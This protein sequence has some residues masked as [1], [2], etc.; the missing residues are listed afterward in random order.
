MNVNILVGN[1]VRKTSVL[2]RRPPRLFWLCVVI[3]TLL[4]VIYYGLV[5]ADV[6]VSEARF[7]V[8][9]PQ[10]QGSSTLGQLLGTNLGPAQDDT[11]TV[12]DYMLS[13]DALLELDRQLQVR[14]SFGRGD[15][16]A[17]FP[18][19]EYDD[20][21]ENM[22]RYYQKKIEVY[23]DPASSIATLKVRSFNAQE[24][25]A[26]NRKLLDM[27]ESLVN[28]INERAR[29]D[30]L[31]HAASDLKE[32]ERKAAEAALALAEYRNHKGIIDPDKQSSL[33]LQQVTKWQ[34][35]LL[36]AQEQLAQLQLLSQ[37]NPQI[38]VLRERIRILKTAIEEQSRN[39]A[40]GEQSLAS[41][42]AQYQRLVLERDFADRQ[43]ASALNSLEQARNDVRRQQLYLERI[44]GPS[45]P[46]AALEPRRVRSIASVL[47]LGLIAWGVL[48][49]LTA[50]IREHMD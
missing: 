23:F 31:R 20:S 41:K 45:L 37:E 42:A 30:M 21:F 10:R 9:S 8:R 40:G 18:G 33:Q 6:Y 14:R 44:T 15:L 36:A 7:I 12:L 28:R 50:G 32:T 5:A 3:P 29:Q 24:A 48:A 11:Y 27:G 13:R 16:L 46:D 1:A 17:R 2:L 34:D 35:E 19:L 22:H 38:P 25:Q 47:L 49:M 39:V 43:L 4:M 26:I